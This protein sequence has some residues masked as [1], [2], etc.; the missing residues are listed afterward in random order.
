MR[1]VTHSLYASL[2]A[3]LVIERDASAIH[4]RIRDEG[5][6][7]DWN[8]FLEMSPTRAF[9]THG[10]G[11]AMSNL[12]SFDQLKFHGCGNEVVGSIKL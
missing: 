7:F 1:P 11:I 12:L 8:P 4:Y 10:R 5:K 2:R 9:D 6:G 3:H